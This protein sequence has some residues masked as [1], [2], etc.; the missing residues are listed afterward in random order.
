MGLG[1]LDMSI[2]FHRCLYVYTLLRYLSDPTLRRPA[3]HF[4]PGPLKAFSDYGR[5]SLLI[6]SL[7]G[8]QLPKFLN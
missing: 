6:T 2:Y 4:I 3:E 5:W 8:L 7:H 1:N